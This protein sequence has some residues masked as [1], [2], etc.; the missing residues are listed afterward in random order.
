M[1]MLELE[2]IRDAVIFPRDRKRLV[3]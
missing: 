3:P 1:T 2:N